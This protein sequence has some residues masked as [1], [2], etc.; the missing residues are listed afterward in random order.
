MSWTEDRMQALSELWAQGLS[1]SQIAMRLGGVT[2]NAVI[3]KAHRMGLQCRPSPIRSG[4][5]SSR[6]RRR[7]ADRRAASRVL[8]TTVTGQG[9]FDD[10]PFDDPSEIER[11]PEPPLPAAMRS[12]AVTAVPASGDG[13]P[14][15]WPIGDPGADNFHFCN[16][17]AVPGRSY[18]DT[19]CAVAYI[20]R[21][22]TARNAA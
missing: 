1:A 10:M 13:P 19:H 15:L 7:A 12:T 21:D 8:A 6:S 9:L 22:K 5:G 4:G 3:G 18:C 11:L 20:S 14:C 16:G 17:P 2:R